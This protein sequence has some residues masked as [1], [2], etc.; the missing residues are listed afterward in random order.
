MKARKVFPV[1]LFA[2]SI[3]LLMSCGNNKATTTVHK[4]I[5]ID[6]ETEVESG[7]VAYAS[8]ETDDL[9][10]FSGS[11]TV[12]MSEIKELADF[13]VT[14]VTVTNVTIGTSC[15]KEGSYY[16]ENLLLESTGVSATVNGVT[17]GETISSNSTVNTLVQTVLETLIKNK[18]V[19]VSTSGKTNLNPPGE[20]IIYTLTIDA[21]WASEVDIF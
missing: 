6:I 4:T 11:K 9:Y 13:D 15:S 2:M 21:K 7:A 8:L 10:S 17:I 14:G 18:S 16:I 12:N 5:K 1:F 19:L 3:V 20:K